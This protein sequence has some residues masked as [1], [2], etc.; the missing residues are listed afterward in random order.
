MGN[1]ISISGVDGSGKTSIIDE[2]IKDLEGCDVKT[3]YVWLR[4]NHYLTKG[5]L[6]F[7]RLTGYTRYQRYENSRVGYH[8]FYRSRII[9]WLFIGLTFIDTLFAS[10][11]KV[12]MPAIFTRKTTVCDRWIFDIMVDLEVDTK[13]SFYQGTLLNSMFKSLI[14]KKAKCFLIKREFESV[15][16]EREES[17]ND[18]NFPKRH[19]LYIKHST[20]AEFISINNDGT[21]EESVNQIKAKLNR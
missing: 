2:L 6:A 15:R 3:K 13:I 8:E 10:I 7:C 11:F 19:D 9:S 1:I 4:Y 20:D 17:L 5:L 12:Y 16:E 21:I 14:P 18:S